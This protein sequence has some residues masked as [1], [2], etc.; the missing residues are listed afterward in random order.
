MSYYFS[1]EKH[2]RKERRMHL[3]KECL[4]EGMSRQ[5]IAEEL[6]VSKETIRRDINELRYRGEIE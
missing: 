5:E 3:V 4:K 6:E 2:A 1:A